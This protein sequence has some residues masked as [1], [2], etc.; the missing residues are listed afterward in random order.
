MVNDRSLG[1]ILVPL[2]S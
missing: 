1:Y 2:T